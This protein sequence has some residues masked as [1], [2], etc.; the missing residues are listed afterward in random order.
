MKKNSEKGSAIF[1]ALVLLITVCY[2]AMTIVDIQTADVREIA[3]F[4]D[5]TSAY[6]MALGGLEVGY[7]ALLSHLSSYPGDITYSGGKTLFDYYTQKY[8]STNFKE[9]NEVYKYVD[10]SKQVGQADVSIYMAEY[11]GMDWVVIKSQGRQVKEVDS[12][13]KPSFVNDGVTLYIRINRSNIKDIYRDGK[14]LP[15]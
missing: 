15:N 12:L 10:G 14:N 4:K 3:A 1:W 9:L 2:A 5:N 6:Y 11:Y 13:G 7:G 8:T